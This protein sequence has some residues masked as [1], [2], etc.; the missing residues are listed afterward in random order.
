MNMLL[1]LF[2]IFVCGLFIYRLY[3]YKEIIYKLS[4]W[5][6]IYSSVLYV[7]LFIAAGFGYVWLKGWLQQL[8]IFQHAI[9]ELTV[10]LCY[11]GI[12]VWVAV[13]ILERLLPQKIIQA[14]YE[15]G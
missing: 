11:V 2:V 3:Q 14:V 15:K 9:M 5:E 6:R 10:L 12:F 7:G 4:W 13:N 1:V 8:E